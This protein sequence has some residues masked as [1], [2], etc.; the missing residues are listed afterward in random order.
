[1]GNWNNEPTT[2]AYAWKLDG[3]AASTDVT[4]PV[5][6]DD[7]GKLATCIVT[8]TNLAGSTAAPETDPLEIA[9]FT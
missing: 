6:V 8:A 9:A 7:V 5:T 1:M 4:Q 3:T 2:Y